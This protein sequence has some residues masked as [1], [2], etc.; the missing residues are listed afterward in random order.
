MLFEQ[1]T[2]FELRGREPPGRTCTSATGCFCDKANV[3]KEYLRVDY[4]IIYC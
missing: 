1:I 3:S 4:F 2:E